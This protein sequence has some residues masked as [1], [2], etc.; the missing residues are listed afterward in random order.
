MPSIIKT[1]KKRDNKHSKNVTYVL[2]ALKGFI[3]FITGTSLVSLLLLKSQ[4]DNISL[5]LFAYLILALGGFISGFSAY[6]K[7]K[8]RGFLNGV[9]ASGIYC[10]FVLALVIILMR[11]NISANILLMV[12]I[13]VGAGF[14]G[15]TVG[16]NT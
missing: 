10:A 8:N 7:L 3:F 16:A 11:F 5:Y 13:S 15:G 1:K 14:L 12:P 4:N 6:K 9:V 2:C